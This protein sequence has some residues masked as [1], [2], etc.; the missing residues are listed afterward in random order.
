MTIS[1]Y[2]FDEDSNV[3]LNSENIM[4]SLA[5]DAFV[6]ESPVVFF[7]NGFNIL[8]REVWK[9]SSKIA[10]HNSCDVLCSAWLKSVVFRRNQFLV[11][12]QLKHKLVVFELIFWI[13]WVSVPKLYWFFLLI[14]SLKVSILLDL[15]PLIL[16]LAF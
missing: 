5:Q 15:P 3:S 9:C 14:S 6:E 1:G 11:L 12:S 16:F 10:T 8:F 2:N 7:V 13:S 4:Y